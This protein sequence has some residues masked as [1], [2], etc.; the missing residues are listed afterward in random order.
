MYCMLA[1]SM[2]S[3][4]ASPR[5]A[6]CLQGKGGNAEGMFQRLSAV[7]E[8]CGAAWEFDCIDAP[9]IIGVDERAWWLNPPGERSYTASK[10]EGDAVAI[11]LVE[12]AWAEASIASRPYDV[13]LGFS[14]GAMLAAVVASRGLLG[15]G[16]VAP[17][18]MVLLGAATPKPHEPLLRELA[19]ATAAA[20]VP[21]RSLHCLSK[22]DGINPAEMGEWVAGCFGPRAQVLWH[23]SGHVIPGDRG[24]ADAEAVAAVAAFLKAE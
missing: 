8:A 23:A 5:R 1:L 18:S 11:A 6:L 10:Y 24:E 7:R 4:S 17:S 14:Q 12:A 21:T 22:A 16:P 9:Q 19:A 13:L 20:A 3:S 2:L 15:K